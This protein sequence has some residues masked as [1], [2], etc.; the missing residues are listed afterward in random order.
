VVITYTTRFNIQQDRQCTYNVTLRRVHETIY[1]VEKRCLTHFSVC[2]CVFECVHV[3]SC[4]RTDV[5]VGWGCADAGVC[6]RACSLNNPACNSPPYHLSSAASLAPPCFSTLSHKRNGLRNAVAEHK[7]R[8]L[9][10]STILVS[11]ISHYK[12]NSARYCHKCRNVFM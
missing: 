3:R 11:N 10:F 8:V 2:V 5:D 7:M 6:L 9:V 12:K 4:A 1:V